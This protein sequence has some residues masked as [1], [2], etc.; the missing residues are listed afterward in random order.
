MWLFLDYKVSKNEIIK[1]ILSIDSKPVFVISH[2]TVTNTYFIYSIDKNNQLKKEFKGDNPLK[3]E[4]KVK[5]KELCEK[6]FTFKEE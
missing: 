3:L 2:N 1:T 4:E 6:Y 5:Y